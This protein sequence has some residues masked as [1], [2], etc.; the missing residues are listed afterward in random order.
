[1]LMNGRLPPARAFLPMVYI[2]ERG[3]LPIQEHHGEGVLGRFA[4]EDFGSARS[5][6]RESARVGRTVLRE[7]SLGVEDFLATA[8]D[9]ADGTGGAAT[10]LAE[11]GDG[12]GGSAG[13]PS[14]AGGCTSVFRLWGASSGGCVCR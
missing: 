8:A 2:M 10:R 7:P 14:A 1:M 3:S 9:G 5:E 6:G 11:P 12:G 13:G 4:S